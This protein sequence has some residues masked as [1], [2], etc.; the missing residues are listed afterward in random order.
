MVMV[1]PKANY[2]Q[3]KFACQLKKLALPHAGMRKDE[4]SGIVQTDL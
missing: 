4:F 3:N 1:K 2:T